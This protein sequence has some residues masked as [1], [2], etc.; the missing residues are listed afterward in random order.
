MH[1]AIT[2]IAKITSFKKQNWF[3]NIKELYLTTDEKH[4]REILLH[5]SFSRLVDLI[6]KSCENGLE[7]DFIQY[8]KSHK[9]ESKRTLEEILFVLNILDQ[10]KNNLE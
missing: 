4:L 9:L 1:E 2:N 5:L 3:E 10:I 7:K 6:E 8:M